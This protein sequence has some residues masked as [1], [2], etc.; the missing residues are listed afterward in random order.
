LPR[1]SKKRDLKI[2][3][4][5][6]EN[7]EDPAA[8][9]DAVV[10]ADKLGYDIAWLGDHFMPWIASGNRSAFVWSVMGSA[11]EASKK[12]KVG[13][14]VTTPIGARYHPAIIAQA[15]ATLDN[16]YPGRFALGVG[17]GEAMNEAMFLPGGWPAW[18]VRTERLV[19][20][21]QLMKKLWSSDTYFDFDGSYFKLNQVYLYTKPRT[22]IKV[23]FS[24]IGEKFAVIAGENG[25]GL[26]TTNSRNPLERCRDVLFPNFDRGAK[27]AGKDPAK[28]EKILTLS[29]TMEDPDEYIKSHKE[30][31][32]PLLIKAYSEP[33]PRRIEAMG[34]ELTDE[35]ILSSTN[36]CSKWSD[37]AEL[38]H[39]FKDIGVTQVVLQSGPDGKKIRQFATKILSNFK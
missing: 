17:T 20:G 6:G 15:C 23:H 16:M 2:S 18:N 5:I 32:G 33:D 22:D 24:A 37:V 11:L 28:L 21:V 8:F 1:K 14:Y 27:N 38:I 31:S 10:L 29:F 35:K 13:P 19:E 12:I 36:F 7:D 4:D 34:Q 26:I 9:R 39:R 25:D 3:L 30:H